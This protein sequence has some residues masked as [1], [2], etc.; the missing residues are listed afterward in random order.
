MQAIAAYYGQESAFVLGGGS[1]G[2]G[3]KGV[4]LRFFVPRHEMSMCV[5]AT[6]AAV[7]ALAAEGAISGGELRAETASGPCQVSWDVSTPPQVTVEQQ[8]PRIGPGAGVAPQLERALRL[9]AGVVDDALPIR[10]SSVSRAKLIVPLRRAADVHAADPDLDLLWQ[11]CR[12]EG[13]T[14]AYLFAAHPD[15]RDG[16]VVARQFPVDAGFPEDPATGVAAGA[17]AAYLA[18]EAR[19]AS[20]VWVSADIE[21]GEAMG[22]PSRLHASAFADAGGVHRSIVRGQ[23]TLRAQE[24]LDLASLPAVSGGPA[25]GLR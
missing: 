1:T 10:S 22:R 14:G 7:T 17:L 5:H 21:Q 16:H 20:P 2:S 23:A 13:T 24:D 25:P 8:S 6:V 18:F 4:R 3:G 15:G 19:P 12:D 9:P 11:V